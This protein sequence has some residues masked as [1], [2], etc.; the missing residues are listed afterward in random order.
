MD[1]TDQ[2]RQ[3]IEI[4]REQQSGPDNNFRLTIEH[5]DGAWEIAMSI[6]FHEAPDRA[7]RVR[8]VGASFD[9]AW[10]NMDPLWA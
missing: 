6:T 8:G 9:Q 7:K 3:V 5:V 4:L 10:D 1:I 2:E